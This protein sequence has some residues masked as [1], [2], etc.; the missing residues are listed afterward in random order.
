[1]LGRVDEAEKLSGT[2]WDQPEYGEILID[3]PPGDW[4]GVVPG[5]AI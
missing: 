2:G 1:M 4:K 3:A 5:E